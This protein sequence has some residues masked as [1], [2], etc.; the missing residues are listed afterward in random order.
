M[1]WQIILVLSLTGVSMLFFA[2]EWVSPD[3]TALGLLLTLTISGLLPVEK[4]FAGFGS[5]AVIVILGLFILAAA[6]LRTGVVDFAGQRL[7][8]YTGENPFRLLVTIMLTTAVMST[9]I[10]NTASAAFFMPLVFG[11]ARRAKMSPSRLLMPMAFAAILASSITIIGTS[12]NIVVSAMMTRY[13]LDP[14]GVFELAPVGIPI[15]IAGLVYMLVFG[16]RLIPDRF[17]MKGDE[18]AD[19]PRVIRPYLTEIELKNDSSMVGEELQESALRRDFD[20]HVLRI[21]RGEDR[22]LAPRP[23]MKLRAGDVVLIEGNR[24]EILKIKDAPGIDI[25]GDIRLVDPETDDEEVGLAEVIIPP[26]SLLA[27][28]T[29]TQI[30]FRQRYGLQV[31]GINRHGDVLRSKLGDVT[32]R[33]GDVLLVQGEHANLARLELDSA[34][35]ILGKL[36]EPSMRPTRGPLAVAIFAGALALATFNVLPLPVAILLGAL[37]VFST[38]CIGTEDAY[39]QVE[40][41]ALILIACMLGLGAAME[42]TGTA[43]YLADRIS[44]VAGEINPMWLL[45]AFFF[46]AI[47]LTQP[48]SNQAAA[49]VILPVAME[50]A[51]QLSLNPRTFAIMIAVAA[52][53]SFLTPLEPACVIVYGAGR[54]RFFDFFKVGALLTLIIFVIASLLVPRLWPIQEVQSS[55]SAPSKQASVQTPASG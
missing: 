53:A 16:C 26:R 17:A 10:S 40:W 47:L 25:K 41:R 9:F 43:A 19:S 42:Q 48:M 34:F 45:S 11:V 27:R 5:D 28:R 35:Q 29:L 51:A 24:D 46:L 31:L 55:S 32:L 30:G 7:F 20:V 52:S 37:L 22:H 18:K 3:V 12:T 14:I 49:I 8:R 44:A 54:Y 39:R 1:T 13:G 50:T 23:S 6:L 2:F 38:G 21:V 15:A 36:D 33:V 4:A